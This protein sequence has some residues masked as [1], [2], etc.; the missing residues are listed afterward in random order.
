MRSTRAT[1]REAERAAADARRRADALEA[2]CRLLRGALDALPL[3]VVVSDRSGALRYQNRRVAELG[4]VRPSD[5]LV[6][7]ALD[8]VL[9]G[10]R[11][12]RAQT[13]TLDL[14]GPPP[15]TVVVTSEPVADGSVAGAVAVVEDVTERRR[16]DAVRRDFVANVSHELRTPIGA[17]AVLAET[18]ASEPDPEA[19]RRLAS[20]ILTET[21]RMVRTIEDFLDLSRI[22]AGAAHGGTPVSVG[23]VVAAAAARVAPA[24]TR[25]QVR[26][27]LGP[28]PEHLT[29]LGNETQ[30]VSAVANLLD[31]A[32]K[33]SEPGSSAEVAVRVDGGTTDIVVRD[34]GIGI[35][36][37]DLNRVFERFYRVDR[38][39]SRQTG[40]T[41][42]G[43]AIVRHV[44]T[45]HGGTVVV[46]SREGE[47]STF[48][49]RIPAGRP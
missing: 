20:H 15:R 27:D 19:S 42:L 35:P 38:A 9:D 6:S 8:E 24:A 10:V 40:G 4:E 45:N 48:V 43:L 30:L 3:G 2:E 29:I 34:H 25:Q 41:G 21:E 39:R 28:V 7:S 26:I 22:E 1:L 47:G 36:T 37:R 33:Y 13:R 11:S 18:L 32:V 5:V 12:G 49:L 23:A 14:H 44:A 16:L 31:N 17:L 46:D